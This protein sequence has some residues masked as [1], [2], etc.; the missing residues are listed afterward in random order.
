MS[1]L[2]LPLGRW[3]RSARGAGGSA[4]CA[5]A[6]CPRG[7]PAALA[8]GPA[9]YSS[10]LDCRRSLSL[11]PA[12]APARGRKKMGQTDLVPEYQSLKYWE[13]WRGSLSAPLLDTQLFPF[14]V[15]SFLFPPP[16]LALRPQALCPFTLSGLWPLPSPPPGLACSLGGIS[17]LFFL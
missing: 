12:P 1:P 17:S 8:I 2:P 3:G 16:P 4:G 6:R 15:P 11:F 5:S 14:P 9:P 7:L 13:G 10:S